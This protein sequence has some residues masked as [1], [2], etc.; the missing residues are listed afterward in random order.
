L[1]LRLMEAAN[2]ESAS[3]PVTKPGS[4]ARQRSGSEPAPVAERGPVTKSG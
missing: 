3:G 2:P 1:L 4:V